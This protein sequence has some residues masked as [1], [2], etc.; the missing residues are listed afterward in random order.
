MAILI[1]PMQ[2]A[3][4][5]RLVNGGHLQSLRLLVVP[6]NQQALGIHALPQH[7]G[8][9]MICHLDAEHQAILDT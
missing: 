2:C 8:L 9:T 4:E 6:H 1:L 5:Q 7:L 3:G